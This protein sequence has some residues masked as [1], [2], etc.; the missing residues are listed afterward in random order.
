MKDRRKPASEVTPQYEDSGIFKSPTTSFVVE[1]VPKFGKNTRH[2]V[3]IKGFAQGEV[4]IDVV[5]AGR[6]KAQV[7]TVV[8]EL[9]VR[10]S[11]ANH[12][13]GASGIPPEVDDVRLPVRIE[14]SW[15]PRFERDDQGWET[16]THQLF[17]ARWLLTDKTGKAV[18]F[19]EPPIRTTYTEATAPRA[20][21]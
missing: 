16:R 11:R 2:D 12:N 10:W 4:P 20:G 14:G 3:M 17:A 7:E 9:R 5:F 18:S 1:L 8:Q 6:R 13:L 15:R 19:G 21:K